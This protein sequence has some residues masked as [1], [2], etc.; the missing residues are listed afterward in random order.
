MKDLQDTSIM[1]DIPK[2]KSL[3]LAQLHYLG[4]RIDFRPVHLFAGPELVEPD[5]VGR[6]MSGSHFLSGVPVLPQASNPI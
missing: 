6:N 3:E 4:V 1:G 2:L 5:L